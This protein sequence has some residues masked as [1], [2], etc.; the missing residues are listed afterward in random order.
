MGKTMPV[1]MVT[2]E[3][4][5]ARIVQAVQARTTNYI[6]KLFEPDA[7]VEKIKAIIEPG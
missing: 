6:I 5:K 7:F 2:T 3:S 4:E 1:V